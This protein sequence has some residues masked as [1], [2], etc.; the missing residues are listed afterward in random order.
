MAFVRLRNGV[1]AAAG[2][3]SVQ[4]AASGASQ[5]LAATPASYPC[6]GD[7]LTVLP[8]QHPAQISN[9]RTMSATPALLAVGLAAGAVAAL[10][11]T[12]FASVR[13]RRRDLAVL[14]T[15]GFTKRQVA[16]TVAWQAAVAAIIGI[17][18]GVPLGIILGR[19]LWTLFARQIYAI[20]EPTVPIGPVILLS[21]GTLVL[22]NLVA[23]LPGWAAARTP[24][25][26]ALR[27]E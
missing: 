26:L 18:A 25:A 17:A 19:W 9:Y 8:V 12:L 16:A 24:A 4:R 20:P 27:A 21:L 1:S 5:A 7:T 22:V 3:A 6:H 14:K 13:R 10:G 11:L 15:I 2:L 23:A